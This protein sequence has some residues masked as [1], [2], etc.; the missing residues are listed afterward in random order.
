[1]GDSEREGGWLVATVVVVVV[2]NSTVVDGLY[3][4]RALWDSFEDDF[5]D[6]NE[7]MI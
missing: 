5:V 2:W 3:V 7:N 4:G 1:M 6:D